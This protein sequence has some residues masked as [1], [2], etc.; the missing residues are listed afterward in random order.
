MVLQLAAAPLAAQ[1]PPA[2]RP[3][4]SDTA[5]AFY[6]SGGTWDTG[7]NHG[8]YRLLVARDGSQRLPCRL[9]I[10]WI[11]TSPDSAAFVRVFRVVSVIGAPWQLRAPRFDPSPPPRVVRATVA[12]SDEHTGLEEQWVLTLGPPGLFSVSPV[13]H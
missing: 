7:H 3:A 12:G 5:V 6:V 4:P 9:V 1:S 8:Y 11:E 2:L 10:E 13:R